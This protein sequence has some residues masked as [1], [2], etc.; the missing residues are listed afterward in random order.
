MLNKVIQ[1]GNL[2]RDPETRVTQNG[3]TVC[4]FTIAVN[5]TWEKE[6]T[7]FLDVTT[8]NKTAETCQKYLQ[9]GSKVAIDGRLKMDKWVDQ[10]GVAKTKITAIAESVRF[11]GR[12]ESQENQQNATQ[13]AQAS[14]PSAEPVNPPTSEAPAL[15]PPQTTQTAP[16]PEPQGLSEP[17]VQ[18][19][20]AFGDI[21]DEDI[22]F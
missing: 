15:P 6:G 5:S 21:P 8:W 18:E 10:L 1:I 7:L 2:T 9:K 16:A 4:S 19:E 17:G 22:P 12:P 14:N 3:S 13:N 20:N 11:L